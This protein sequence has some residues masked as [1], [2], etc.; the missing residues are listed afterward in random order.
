MGKRTFEIIGVVKDFHFQPVSQPI[1][2]LVIRNESFAS[3]CLVKLR[4][5]NIKSLSSVIQDMKTVVSQLSPSFPVEVS[6]FDQAVG[7]MYESELRFQRTFFLFA[8]CAIV[9]CCLGIFTMSLFSC[10]RRTKE[11]G[12]RKING[13]GTAE[14]MA[15]LNKDLVKLVAVAFIIAMPVAWYSMH[16]WLDGFAYRTQISWWIFAATGLSAL[17]IALLTV[18]WQTWRAASR[19]PVEALRYE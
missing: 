13:A 19:N 16:K 4:T 9:I 8:I 15:L 3:Y 18:T 14:V 17:G 6:F 1:V 5:S 12:I 7:N 2:P 11:I 10:Q